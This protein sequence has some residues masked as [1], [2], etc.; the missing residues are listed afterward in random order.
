MSH[1]KQ[2]AKGWPQEVPFSSTILEL[3]RLPRTQTHRMRMCPSTLQ[4]VMTLQ[5]SQVILGNS[6]VE[7]NIVLGTREQD[8]GANIMYKPC[9]IPDI[10][11]NLRTCE[12]SPHQMTLT[13]TD[14][15]CCFLKTSAWSSDG[16]QVKNRQR[17][18]QSLFF[19][20]Y[21]SY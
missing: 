7:K 20:V 6:K 15:K 4:P 3:S 17:R 11:T 10:L 8:P 16:L 1:L 19:L 5:A 21:H 2:V 13:I 18:R 12:S 9:P 14:C